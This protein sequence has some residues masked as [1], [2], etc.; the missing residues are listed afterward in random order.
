MKRPIAVLV[1]LVAFLVLGFI[2]TQQLPVS[3]LPSIDIPE[4]SVQV[5]N[6]NMDALDMENTIT[7]KMRAGLMQV[8]GLDKISSKSRDGHSFIHMRFNYGTD[9]DY[10]FMEVNEKIDA[11]M[12]WL[13]KTTLRPGVIKA[14]ASDIPVFDIAV[15][16]KN[17]EQQDFLSLSEFVSR[18][19]RRRIE[20]L[21]EVAIADMSGITNPQVVI[22]PIPE[23]L[24]AHNLTINSLTNAFRQQ[25]TRLGAVTLRDGFYQ[26]AVN[27][28]SQASSPNDIENIMLKAGSRIVRMKDVA[29]VSIEPKAEQGEFLFN[30]KKGVVLSII[31]NS[32]T[33]MQDLQLSFS[34]LL[35][36][37][38]NDYPNLEFSLSRDQTQLL[39]VS[40]N[41]LKQNLVYGFV[42]AFL[43]MFLM[44]GSFRFSSLMAI[45]IPAS[46][47]ITML[48]FYLVG[49]TINIISL[50]G[51]I[52]GAGMMIDN[53][54]IVIDNITQYRQRGD[55]LF[56]ACVNGTNEVIRPLITSVLTTCAVFVPLIFLSGISGALFFDQ[57]T[58]I[59]IGLIVS[60]LVSILII[61]VLYNLMHN[62]KDIVKRII[63]SRFRLV[64]VYEKGLKVVYPNRK[65]FVLIFLL[66]VPA[67]YYLYQ[68]IEKQ[69]IPEIT[70]NDFVVKLD[71]NEKVTMEENSGRCKDVYRFLEHDIND[72]TFFIGQ[73]QFL[74]NREHEN[75]ISEVDIVV[76]VAAAELKQVR[77]NLSNYLKSY[78]PAATFTIQN[79]RNVF[80]SLFQTSEPPLV[81]KLRNRFN[82]NLPEKVIVDELL[83]DK[84]VFEQE[85]S[86]A[87]K[88]SLVLEIDFDKL[89][90]YD[91]PYNQLLNKLKSE[92]QANN[93]S[94]VVFNQRLIPVVLSSESPRLHRILKKS[95][96]RN[97]KGVLIP[98]RDLLSIHHQQTYK[99]IPADRQ[100]KYVPLIVNIEGKDIVQAKSTVEQKLLKYPNLSYDYAGSWLRNLKTNRELM[101]VLSISVLLLF[102]ILAAQ[103]ES[104][105]QPF[106]VLLEVFIDIAG[107]LLLLKLFGVSLNVMSAIGIIVMSGII[108]NDSIIKVDTINRLRSTGMGVEQAVYEAGY[109][110]FNPI[111]MT[112][113]TTIL[114]L[115][116]LFFTSGLGVELQLPLAISVIG[117]MSLGTIVSLY[118]IPAFYGLIY[119]R[120]R[121]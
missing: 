85:N 52:L 65:I 10:S 77:N 19:I 5:D 35:K 112:S 83:V 30:G 59:A 118:F 34:H 95:F 40:I 115:V 54:I 120:G 84:N 106:I 32:N 50:S 4:I 103:F 111:V 26:Y 1:S 66:F 2:T 79:T 58:A 99:T 9:I 31:K 64:N 33:R 113:L 36:E 68:N 55:K 28:R 25:N 98:L 20:Q 17:S 11:M 27:I 94:Q 57:A 105:I 49:L 47:V 91:V 60:L 67:G 119:D 101:Y 44:L 97:N 13:P 29:D 104:L 72:M 76:A 121:G 61:P 69:L 53:S 6:P 14:S 43:L 46:L 16:Y 21:P 117:G 90:L 87:L 3:L 18:I 96:V 88:E 93:F 110:R 45:T 23:K 109:R 82:D 102:F 8:S 78:Y 75:S 81:I 74:L 12:R 108:I 86:M 56:A 73:Q 15:T 89:Y 22:T 48:V 63:N 62:D 51:L 38:R 71:W 100:G 24:H 116:P 80:E 7:R 114:A 41:N 42:L 37:L 39:D 107:A 92:L 70:H